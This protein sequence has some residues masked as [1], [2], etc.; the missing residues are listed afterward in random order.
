MSVP[1]DPARLE[2]DSGLRN[3]LQGS[4][5]LPA[6]TAVPADA[7]GGP[8]LITTD[9]RQETFEAVR[10][11]LATM[12]GPYG[13]A[14]TAVT[15]AEQSDLAGQ[16]AETYR[17]ATVAGLAVVIV[18]GGL[19]LAVSLADGLRERIPAHA[20]MLAAGVP[21]RVLRRSLLLQLSVPLVGTVALATGVAVL[22][23]A[24]YQRLDGSVPAGLP[25]PVYLAVAS[26][27]LLASLLAT[28]SVLPFLRAARRPESLR[29][30]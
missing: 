27:A 29:T 22:C 8:G 7:L 4:L 20:A 30:G 21:V 2:V 11:V 17:R 10:A 24:M 23:G 19:V 1:P 13:S 5:R 9:G 6:D 25:W 18:V 28:I 26:A 16:Q 12:P 3:L 14:Y 15:A